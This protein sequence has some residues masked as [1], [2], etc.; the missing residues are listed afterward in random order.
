V[1]FLKN[2][3]PARIIALGLG[4]LA[5][6]LI[7][8]RPAAAEATLI[9]EADSGKVLH[10]EHANYPWYPASVT[11]LMTAYVILRAI[12]ER[13]IT[14]DSLFTA[15]GNAVA[16]G[17]TKMGFPVG[18]TVTVDN[19][20][21]MLMVKSANDVA[22]V[23]AEGLSGSIEKFADEM[24]AASKRLGMTQSSWVN[25]NGLPADEQITSARDMAILARALILEFPEYE[26]YWRIPAIRYGR[27]TMPNH[28]G[29]MTYYPGTDGMKTGFICASG[30]NVVAT[31][32]RN[33]RRLI[34]IVFGSSSGGAR[35]VKAAQL[36][37]KG[38]NGSGL[39]WLMP[40]LGTVD[41]LQPIAAA[42]P[43]L[44]DEMCGPGR[45][46]PASEEAE[47]D[48]IA[49]SG[50]SDTDNSSAYAVSARTLRDRL[51]KH[52]TMLG[53]TPPPPM[54][55]VVVYLGPGKNKGETL[56]AA[57]KRKGT[58]AV[59]EAPATPQRPRS[60]TASMGPSFNLSPT[61]SPPPST[62][63]P[64]SAETTPATLTPAPETPDGAAV[65]RKRPKRAADGK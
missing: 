39:S 11:K 14:L 41:A 29:L 3:I 58:T 50:S 6:G 42:P 54:P 57:R 24:N 40:S 9:V 35:T 22:V 56:V 13:R 8:A 16:Q 63:T 31:A 64:A 2:S 55:P 20:L 52:M 32:S 48:E 17:P 18:T 21:K 4:F 27:R 43:N 36:F 10:A 28:N 34:V 33:G 59:V 61:A 45:K 51:G 49:T 5:T 65:K 25:P 46:R 38:F 30:F 12:K 1:A 44:R 23:L 60:A 19:A 37:E 26:M 53:G 15:T 47:N 62:F 7:A